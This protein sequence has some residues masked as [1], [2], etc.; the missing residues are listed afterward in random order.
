[1]LILTEPLAHRDRPASSHPLAMIHHATDGFIVIA[2]QHLFG[3]AP[4]HSMLDSLPIFCAE[5]PVKPEA[6][7][8]GGDHGNG[9]GP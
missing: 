5:Q 6:S 9:G 8:R 7:P 4:W 2:A 3:S 1:M